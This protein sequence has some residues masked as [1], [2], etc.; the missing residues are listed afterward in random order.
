M[1]KYGTPGAVFFLLLILF[2]LVFS[3][4]SFSRKEE[5]LTYTQLLSL[6][7]SGKA[8]NVSKVIITNGDSTVQV[9][10]TGSE[11]ERSVIVPIESKESLIT[12]TKING[13]PVKG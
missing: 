9:K 2:I 8:E 12:E 5:P 11:R 13:Q 1:K 3:L 6:L 4:T 7:Q 10:M